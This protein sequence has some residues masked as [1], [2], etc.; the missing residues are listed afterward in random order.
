M[1]NIA[2]SMRPRWLIYKGPFYK[3]QLCPFETRSMR[4]R[5]DCHRNC[6]L[7]SPRPVMQK[8]D[9]KFE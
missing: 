7:P 4:Y 6:K 9:Y 5:Y 1:E 2:K 8:C 3:C